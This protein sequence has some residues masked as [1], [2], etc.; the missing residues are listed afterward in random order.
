MG[1]NFLIT[2]LGTILLG[3]ITISSFKKFVRDG[4]QLASENDEEG[5]SIGVHSESVM[6][7]NR[8]GKTAELLHRGENKNDLISEH[9]ELT[10][11]DRNRS[12]NCCINFM[13]MWRYKKVVSQ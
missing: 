5:N 12:N 4:A 7:N 9:E 11:A 2:I 1:V 3:W 8:I 6:V 13:K 10:M